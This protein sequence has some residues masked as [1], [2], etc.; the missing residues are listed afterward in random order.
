MKGFCPFWNSHLDVYSLNIYNTDVSL[1][2]WHSRYSVMTAVQQRG[3]TILIV[4]FP[5]PKYLL[6]TESAKEY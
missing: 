3:Q 5:W 2:V 4:L 1:I 6:F